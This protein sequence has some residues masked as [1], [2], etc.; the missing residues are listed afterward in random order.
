MTV[1]QLSQLLKGYNTHCYYNEETPT[2][3]GLSDYY[4]Q[5]KG[6]YEEKELQD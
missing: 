1:G 2:W 4:Q 5:F 6:Y 3:E